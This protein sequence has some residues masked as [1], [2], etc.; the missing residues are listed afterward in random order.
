MRRLW[1]GIYEKK[2]KKEL[3]MVKMKE[4]NGLRER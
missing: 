3:E 2:V 1:K 4:W